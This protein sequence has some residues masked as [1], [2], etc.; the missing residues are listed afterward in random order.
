MIH[1][2]VLLRFREGVADAEIARVGRALEELVGRVPE[3]RRLA[4]GRN[5]APDAEWPWALLVVCDDMAAV[6]RYL[7]HPEHQRVVRETLLPIRAGRI[8]VDL[9][10]PA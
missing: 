8:A 7:D 10:V 6:Q 3:I 1:H 4:F 2:V 5:Q 9:E